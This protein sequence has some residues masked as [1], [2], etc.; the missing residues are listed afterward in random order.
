MNFAIAA[1]Q[2]TQLDIDVALD[3]WSMDVEVCQAGSKNLINAAAIRIARINDGTALYT[4]D[5]LGF[6]LPQ[7]EIARDLFA[8]PAEEWSLGNTYFACRRDERW[9]A[10]RSGR[11]LITDF[12]FGKESVDVYVKA[13]RE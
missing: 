8:N 4:R 1:Q 7:A 12:L 5:D 13:I 9:A 6:E 10:Y 11:P 3:L 2:S